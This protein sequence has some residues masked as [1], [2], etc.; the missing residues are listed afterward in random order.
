MLLKIL[1]FFTCVAALTGCSSGAP[2]IRTVCLRDDIGNYIIKWE[3][4]PAIEGSLKMYVS[5]NPETFNKSN[6]AVY[7]NI[8][9]G[10]ATYVTNDNIKRKYFLLSFNDKYYQIVGGR[11]IVTDSIQNIRD[12]GG[13]LTTHSQ[14][15]TK[16]GKLY[17]SGELSS[18]SEWDSIR[19]A[20]LDIKT[21]ID[22]RTASEG[23]YSPLRYT[24]AN[25]IHIPIATGN[26]DDIPERIDEGH[27]RK[28]DGILYMQDMYLQFITSNSKQFAQVLDH[29]QNQD[30]YPV[31]IN[32]SLGKDRTG[33]LSAML[34]SA[35]GVP[36]ETI[37]KDYMSSNDYIDKSHYAYM[38]RGLDTD[39]Q[40]TIT[41]LLS[42]NE[43]LMELVFQKIDKEYGSID[44]YLSKGLQ[45]T[46][47]KRDR[48]KDILLY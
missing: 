41:V 4:Y 39:A 23:A 35:L 45:L 44:K 20:N 1:S 19:L 40:E 31:I 14:R 15:M 22:L 7:A 24:K 10:V 9:D 33:F 30:N 48:L 6:P 42:A 28:G 12:I 2:E 43:S 38:A 29:L 46:E 32:C 25:V 21:I 8:G 5:D 26:M 37:L 18:V 11:A 47:K 34:L 16:W 17:R 27:M 3:T 36:E 13:Y